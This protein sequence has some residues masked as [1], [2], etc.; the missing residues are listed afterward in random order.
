M[1]FTIMNFNYYELLNYSFIQIL[2]QYSFIHWKALIYSFLI[3]SL[4]L[5]LIDLV[6]FIY[7]FIQLKHCSLI[8]RL[9]HSLQNSF[10]SSL[11]L[12][13]TFNVDAEAV[14]FTA[15]RLSLSVPPPELMIYARAIILWR[16]N[17]YTGPVDAIL[18]LQD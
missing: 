8:Q 10:S 3:H 4:I 14:V 18:Y 2:I 6:S 9:I 5:V 1:K 13:Q 15:Y 7:L 12:S 16:H 17:R 11:S